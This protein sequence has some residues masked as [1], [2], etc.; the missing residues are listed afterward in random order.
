MIE[1]REIANKT[2]YNLLLISK[3]A[4]FTQAWFYGEW[5][6]MMGRKVRRFE[7]KKNSE[8]I[9]F[10]QI[11]KYQLSFGQ[12]LLYIPHG[13]VLRIHQIGGRG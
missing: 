8:I 5:Q 1:I 11:I 4:P 3:Q 10:F 13:P 12:N 7:V 6:E 2:E 9:G